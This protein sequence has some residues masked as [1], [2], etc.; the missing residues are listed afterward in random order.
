MTERDAV[1]ALVVQ[2]SSLALLVWGVRRWRAD[3]S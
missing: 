1:T 2:F 3:R